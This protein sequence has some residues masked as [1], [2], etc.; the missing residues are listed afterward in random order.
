MLFEISNNKLCRFHSSWSPKE[1]E[2]EHYLVTS[3]DTEAPI[4]EPTIFGE[5]L[6]LINNQVK[7]RQKKRADIL[8]LDRGGNGVI[9]ELKRN[10]GSL[11]VETQALQYLSDFANFKGRNFIKKFGSETSNTEENILSFMGG[12]ARID[13]V[14][15]NSRIILVARSFD[16]TIYSMGEWLSDKG[17]AFRCIE[18]IPV[19]VNGRQFLTFSIAF[20]RSSESIF[21]ISF[22]ATAREPGIFWHNIASANDDWW[23][24]LV[25]EKEIP[26]CFDDSPGDQGE[27]ILTSYING[28]KIVAYAKGYG[29]VGWGVIENS[30]SYKLLNE[31]DNGDKL[32]GSCLH[33]LKVSWKATATKLSEGMKPDFIREKLGIYHPLS[34]S[35]AIET[36]RG[37]KLINEL[38]ARF[39]A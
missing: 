11:G 8:A 18:Y 5:P 20:D 27:R 25:R 34:T 4:L 37:E 12:N 36:K 17:V 9:V 24:F 6:L 32:N 19:E 26:A 21:P 13:D 29:A 16:P 39:K 31:G 35:V 14:N 10:E 28:D 2:L 3:A 23:N 33:R 7:T 22:A 15:K 38:S 1:L 30:N